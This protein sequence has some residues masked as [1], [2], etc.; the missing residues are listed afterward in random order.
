MQMDEEQRKAKIR[1][2]FN[3]VAEGYD[4]DAL[5]FFPATAQLIAESLRLRGDESVL[6]VATGTGNAAL[7]LAGH[8]PRGR[9]VGVDFSSG[10]LERARG[11]AESLNV[12]N[13]EFLERDMQSLGFSPGR[14]DAAVS[15]FGIFFVEQMEAQLTHIAESVKS[16]GRI[17]ISGFQEN[18]F[19]PLRDLMLKRLTDYGVQT[20]PQSWKRIA[21]EEGCREL[22]RAAGFSDIRVEPRNVGYFLKDEEQW[23]DVIWNAGFRNLVNQMTPEDR[24]RFKREHLEE[25]AALT[26]A[27]GLWLDV[28]ILITIGVKP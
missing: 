28:G 3:T 26:T 25:V 21:T 4:S 7:A 22:F 23:W 13:V 14:F 9:V 1:E 6:D 27:E 19:H 8:L 24:E 12:Q 11:K 20:P 2:T 15:S 16:G 18:Y 10:M 17:A 5:R